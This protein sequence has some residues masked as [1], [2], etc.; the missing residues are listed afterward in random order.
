M[1]FTSTEQIKQYILS[2]VQVAVKEVQEKVREVFQDFLDMYYDDYDPRV[3]QRTYQLLN[4]LVKADIVPT[5]NGF[6]TEVYFNIDRLK[7]DGVSGRQVAYAASEGLHG[8]IPHTTV[9][10]YSG[11]NIWGMPIDVLTAEKREIFKNALI[12]AGIPV[13]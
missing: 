8:A 6:K 1:N 11:I 9:A 3:Y 12:A 13:R 5:G 4:S 2:R 7:Y 10:G